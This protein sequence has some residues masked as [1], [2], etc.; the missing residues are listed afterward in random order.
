MSFINVASVR[1]C[2]E[3]EGTGKR[4]ALWVQGCLN[5]C[6][7]CCNSEMQELRPNTI[8]DTADMIGIIAS[9]AERYGIEGVSFIGGE[10]FLQAEGLADI[11]E[12][13]QSNKLSVLVFTGYLYE[14]LS[15]DSDKSVRKLL[16]N[17]DI[18]VDGPFIREE[19]DEERDW[20]GSKNQKV[21]YLS[22]RYSPGV[23]YQNKERTMEFLISDNNILINGWPF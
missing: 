22:D 2:T 19:Y 20:V 4:F 12:W 17:T 5:R 18:L 21:I 7:G 13:C 15:S 14:R 11:A 9:A 23:E 6:P 1:L 10:P 8:V 3:A 16:Q